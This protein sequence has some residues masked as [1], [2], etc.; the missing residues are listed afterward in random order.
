MKK[1]FLLL[2]FTSIFLILSAQK[3]P[4]VTIEQIKEQCGDIPYNKRLRLSVSNF[5]VATPNASGKFGDELSQ[6]LTNAL[7][8]VNCF[9]VLLS[10]KDT[11]AIS[12]EISFSQAGNTALKSGPQT[13]KMKGPQVVVLGK[14]TEF[15]EGSN[16]V[17]AFGLKIGGNKAKIGFI[18]QL[19]NAQ[20][21]EVMES[22]SINVEGNANG[23]N[24]AKLFG[25]EMVGNTNNNKALADACEKGIIQA[26]EFIASRK[27]KMNFSPEE[28]AE[29]KKYTVENCSILKSSYIPK[30]M[31]ILPE[32]HITERI[33]DPA[34]ETE[35]NRKLIESGFKV[36]DAAMFATIKNGTRFI[37]ASHNPKAAI[38]LGK[39]F[40]AD[41]VIYGEAFSQRT[42]MQG[43]QVSCRAR[44]EIKAV[45][46]DDASIIAANGLEA[47][48][49]D[50]AEF[51][52]AKS[53]LRNAGTLVAEYLLDQFCS[54][55]LVFTK[56]NQTQNIQKI[57]TSVTIENADYSKLKVVTDLLNSKG[58]I[59]DKSLTNNIGQFKIDF[60][61]SSE[62]IAEIIS[63][64]LGSRYT[65]KELSENMLVLIAK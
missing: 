5:D 28:E 6:M 31:V 22:K 41:I 12:D 7:Q 4:K 16:S 54:K 10:I 49:L 47:G 32:F 36:V 53:A 38:S 63:K 35:I 45:R 26:V 21:R 34:A 48:A 2:I 27:D 19:V 46:T 65:I 17:G 39:E 61:G 11:K 52:S 18:I 1:L 59:S 42:G 58:K 43:N 25:L 50:N 37:D 44:V 13:G 14:I 29:T 62:N 64:T 24:G 60:K 9:N 15:G 55:N 23:F 30:V 33:P 51:V 57:L 3:K 20:T 56:I 8:N 40:G